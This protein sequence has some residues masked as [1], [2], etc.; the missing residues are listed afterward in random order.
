MRT[1]QLSPAEQ[2]ILSTAAAE[3]NEISDIMGDPDDGNK[4]KLVF[5]FKPLIGEELIT[6]VELS[7]EQLDR[8]FVHLPDMDSNEA[9]AL[10][11]RLKAL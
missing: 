9:D 8:L 1:I 6:T 7:E 5:Q 2:Q 11:L 3:I 10:L 4:P